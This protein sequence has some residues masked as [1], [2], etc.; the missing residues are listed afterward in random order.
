MAQISRY[1]VSTRQGGVLIFI[2]PSN[3]IHYTIIARGNYPNCVNVYDM[4]NVSFILDSKR[5]S[6]ETVKRESKKFNQSIEDNKSLDEKEAG[7]DKNETSEENLYGEE[8]MMKL[9]EESAKAEENRKNSVVPPVENDMAKHE[10]EAAKDESEAGEEILQG[11][12]LMKKLAEENAEAEENRRKNIIPVN[13]QNEV[14]RDANEAANDEIEAGDEILQGE[15]LMRKLEEE[16]AKAEE[17]RR[18]NII[19]VNIPNE[20]KRDT[21]EATIANQDD[22]GIE[23]EELMSQLEKEDGEAEK[24]RKT[25]ETEAVG[26]QNEAVKKN[27]IINHDNNNLGDAG[28][29]TKRTEQKRMIERLERQNDEDN[30][31]LAEMIEKLRNGEI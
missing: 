18:K 20:A 27:G 23:G 9:S 15:E 13:I 5:D 24:E 14:K 16:N 11:E 7:N 12:M 26:K 3:V 2:S 22:E 28:V 1:R 17:N 25:D 6:Q 10:S 21:N 8:L 29:L 4:Y 31:L 19:P 30:R